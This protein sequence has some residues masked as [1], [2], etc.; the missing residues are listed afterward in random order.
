MRLS[1]LKLDYI[2]TNYMRHS[3]NKLARSLGLAKGDVQKVRDLLKLERTAAE[4]E[5]ILRHP[6]APL[7]PYL[8]WMPQ[9]A[10]VFRFTFVDALLALACGAFALVIYTLTLCPTVPG[11]DG[12][13]LIT[14]AYTLGIA[15]PPGYP[16]WCILGKLFTFIPFGSIAWRVNFM[17]AV[18]GALTIASVYFVAV[19][20]TRSRYASVCG[21][22]LLAFSMEFWEQS[23]IAEVYTLNLFFIALCLLLL[24]IW[25]EHRTQL[26]LYSFATV[27]GFS[28]CNHHT[29]PFLAPM[30]LAFLAIVD[31]EP[32][33]RWPLYV[34]C[35][36][37]SLLPLSL[38][39]Y[40]PIRSAANP[41]V[42]WGNPETWGN[43]WE[44]VTR[45]QYT[46]SFTK[47]LRSPER[48]FGQALVF[49]TLP[50]VEPGFQA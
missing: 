4:R 19:K 49:A 7:E 21:A 1:R 46:F 31:R 11:E 25:Y 48:F 23:V 43:F 38:Y 34:T 5:F 3:D 33:R 44:V 13:E 35:L 20:L 24:I 16:L 37:L 47:N 42:D 28:L 45:K 14:A 22:L 50:G 26:A 36:V 15:H 41:P 10:G 29:M 30:F 12:G 8:G 18:F 39:A 32:W 17:S 2:R 6:D 27:F 9:P 40:L